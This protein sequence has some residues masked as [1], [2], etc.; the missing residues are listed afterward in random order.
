MTLLGFEPSVEKAYSVNGSAVVLSCIPK[1]VAF[2]PEEEENA[3]IILHWLFKGSLVQTGDRH[4]IYPNSTLGVL[5]VVDPSEVYTCKG[6]LK[7]RGTL[8]DYHQQ[9]SITVYIAS[10]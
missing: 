9:A 4:L 10:K 3:K 5:Q 8:S 6:Q 2:P 7:W 1:Y